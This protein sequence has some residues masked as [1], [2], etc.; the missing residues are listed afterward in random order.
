[1]KL[2]SY[3]L[4]KLQKYY[5][6]GTKEDWSVCDVIQNDNTLCECGNITTKR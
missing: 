4:E 6:L 5:N 1:M 2:T 3:D